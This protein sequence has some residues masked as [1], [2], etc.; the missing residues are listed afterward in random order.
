MCQTMTTG[1]RVCDTTA[2]L[3][4][5]EQSARGTVQSAM[6]YNLLK[7]MQSARGTNRFE[8]AVAGENEE[9]GREEE[10]ENGETR[11]PAQSDTVG[12]MNNAVSSDSEGR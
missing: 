3:T 7:L 6:F 12:W 1:V 9:M 11:E 10:E 2:N 4:L 5:K 8:D